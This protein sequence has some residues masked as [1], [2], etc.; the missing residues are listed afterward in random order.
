MA[1]PGK[2][3][4]SKGKKAKNYLLYSPE[5]QD[6]RDRCAAHLGDNWEGE[7]TQK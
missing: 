4:G 7:R 2:D 5:L 3:L 1:I 6:D